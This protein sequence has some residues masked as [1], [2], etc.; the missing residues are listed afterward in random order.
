MALAPLWI[1]TIQRGGLFLGRSRPVPWFVAVW[2]PLAIFNIFSFL[3]PGGLFLTVWLVFFVN[4][5]KRN[6][7]LGWNYF[8]E[9]SVVE[10]K[11]QDNSRTYSK[12]HKSHWI[13]PSYGKPLHKSKYYRKIES[14]LSDIS[15][16]CDLPDNSL[17]WD[18]AD[19]SL[20]FA[21]N[22]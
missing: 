4:F 7:F 3:P 15:L 17:G 16:S 19:I 12:H 5:D 20:D 9:L 22:S 14:K 2:N 18:F 6:R 11:F 21:D 10:W 8:Q 1:G 13:V